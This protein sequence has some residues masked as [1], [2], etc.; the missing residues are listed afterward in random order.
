VRVIALALVLAIAA[1]A[2]AEPTDTD[3]VIHL[4]SMITFGGLYLAIE[5]PWKLRFASLECTWCDPPGFDHSIRDALRWERRLVAARASDVLGF[6]ASPIA[7]ASLMVAA[8]GEHRSLRR[9]LD[10]LSPMIES[11]IIVSLMQ[12]TAK[13]VVRRSR[14]F[15]R[16]APPGRIYYHDD[17]TAFWSGHTSAVFAETFACGIIAHERGYKLEPAIWATGITFG[18]VTGYLRLAADMHYASDVAVGVLLGIGVG[19]AVP[20]LLH[21]SSLERDPDP[22]APRV[23]PQFLSFGGAF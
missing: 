21:R 19:I 18:V 14:P 16:F 6:A 10:D 5:F 3:R 1:P 8:G 20:Y 15:V 22:V 13:Y 12:S 23:E 2:R 17:N 7:L 4:G 11:A 9:T